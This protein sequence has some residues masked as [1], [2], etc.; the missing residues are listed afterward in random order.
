M[1]DCGI[2]WPLR[3]FSTTTWEFKTPFTYHKFQRWW[4][5]GCSSHK[6]LFVN[7]SNERHAIALIAHWFLMGWF[8]S[9]SLIH[10][11]Y[12]YN[13]VFE[14]EFTSCIKIF[15]KWNVLIEFEGEQLTSISSSMALPFRV[16]NKI[17]WNDELCKVG[18]WFEC[19]MNVRK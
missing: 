6:V 12:A 9:L 11:R 15:K 4:S 10:G 8:L 3:Y 18:R 1:Q 14:K 7:T 13:V 2:F 19:N 16:W 5:F 17:M